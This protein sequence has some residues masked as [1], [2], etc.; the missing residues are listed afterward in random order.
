MSRALL[1]AQDAIAG[2]HAISLA[3]VHHDP[4][5]VKLGH[6]VG[7]SRVTRRVLFL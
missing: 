6:A 7:A 5:A 2:V 1:I 3:V 4:V